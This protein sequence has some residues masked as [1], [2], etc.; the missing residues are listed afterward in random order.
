MDTTNYSSVYCRHCFGLP[1]VLL[2]QVARRSLF[3][4]HYGHHRAL[5]QFDFLLPLDS[6]STTC[7]QSLPGG[8]ALF[9]LYIFLLLACLPTKYSILIWS[10]RVISFH[11][12]TQDWWIL[13]AKNPATLKPL[14]WPI[15]ATSFSSF[16]FLSLLIPTPQNS[17]PQCGLLER[18]QNTTLTFTSQYSHLPLGG[19]VGE[20]CFLQ[21][22]SNEK[23]TQLAN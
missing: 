16:S 3:P 7:Y 10:G 15:K 17:L 22:V 13:Q 12:S 21:P 1:T 23:V 14:Y 6:K 5:L 9:V 18:C 19:Q 20:E 2:F 4:K 8:L 11:V